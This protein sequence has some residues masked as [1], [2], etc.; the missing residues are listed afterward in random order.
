M[1]ISATT[2]SIKGGQGTLVGMYVNSTSSGTIKLEDTLTHG[3]GNVINNTITPAIGW[4]SFGNAGFIIG[5]S[6]TIGGTLDVTLY[7]Q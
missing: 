5:L 3:S 4:H 7:V 2:D 6:A 1:H